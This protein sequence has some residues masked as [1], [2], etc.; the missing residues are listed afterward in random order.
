MSEKTAASHEPMVWDAQSLTD[1]HARTDKAVRVRAMFDTIAPTYERVNQLASLG[2][3]ARWRRRAVAATQPRPGET[4]V[5][6]CCGTGDML[7]TFAA[8]QPQLRQLIGIDFAA[9]ML[10]AGHYPG[11]GPPIR[12]LRADGLRLPL[13]DE[14]ADI[15]SCAFGVRNFQNLAAG[16]TEMHRVLRPGGRLAILEFARPENPLLRWM[17]AIYCNAVLPRLGSWISR[18]PTGAYRYL[19]RSIEAFEPPAQT[20]ARLR[21]I[22]FSEVSSTAMNL[23][24][25]ILYLARR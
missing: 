3:D 21:Q 13:R 10:A 22:G 11:A 6:V 5:D 20:R 18:D 14:S 19:P 17:N 1:V 8:A 9:G 12:L 16:L 15:A 25:V 7:R 4:I 2:Q 23:G 24:L